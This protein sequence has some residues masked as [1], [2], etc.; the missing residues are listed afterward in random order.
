MTPGGP[1]VVITSPLR[2]EREVFALRRDAQAAFRLLGLPRAETVRLT[3][4]LS[5]VGR[6]LHGAP[7]LTG[8]V[9]LVAADPPR[10]AVRFEWTGDA[11]PAPEILQAAERL[12]DQCE[13]TPGEHPV[14]LLGQHL[15]PTS[16]P[17]AELAARA[18]DELVGLSG[19]SMSEE[20]RNQNHD[21]LAALQQAR[22]HQEE[23]QRLNTELEETNQGVVAL[24][25]E[26]SKELEATNTGVVALY[27]E[28]EDKTRQL[29]LVSESKTRFW[30]NVSHELRSPVN[31]VIGLTRLLL[32][33]GADPLT[34]E[35]RQQIA[36][37]GASG[38]TL[39]ALVEELL[40]VA[41]AESGRL[42]PELVDTDLRSL[43]H[44]LR[45]TLRS[46]AQPGVTLV[47][48]D[49]SH[50][51][52]L[53]TDEVMLTRVLRNVLSNSLKY[54]ETGE[55][56]LAVDCE[57]RRG[58]PWYVFTVTDTG[59]GI[60]EDQQERV[61]EEFYQVRGPHQR[62][63]AGTGLGLPYARKLTELLGGRLSLSSTPG[64]GTTVVVELPAQ[65]R[66]PAP[67]PVA[68]GDDEDG[69]AV[70][71]LDSLVVVDDDPAFLRTLRPV[72]AR[73][74]HNVTEVVVSAEALAAV[75]RLRPD[76]VLLDLSMAPPDGY[77]LLEHLARDRTL[78]S[79]PVVVLTATDH[80]G[81]DRSRLTHARAVLG[82]THLTSGRLAGVL[83]RPAAGRRPEDES[84][85]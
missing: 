30:A 79:V 4:V 68:E 75:R 23:L 72:L 28:L 39:L 24:Y 21:L 70:P 38:S 78:A 56:R 77:Q 1:L 7:G 45:G 2:G 61:F 64:E 42:E 8:R 5:E 3:T 80:E 50:P 82:K 12:L 59:V 15:P 55:V 13:W 46:T 65:T 25:S 29:S 6:Y 48:P 10:V 11:V 22:A 33:P 40:D 66:V 74:A 83:R 27:A 76:A 60:P 54:T 73:L 51:Q 43:L 16:E 18:R 85:P 31:A 81:L 67:G 58:R 44:Q 62:A 52:P 9:S 49:D 32:G 36:L 47:I 19:V 69:P 37:I 20:L 63:A 53:V 57:D 26:L 84:Q 71:V 41:K 17:P 34:A 14:L 35:Q